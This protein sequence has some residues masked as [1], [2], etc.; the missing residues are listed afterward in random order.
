MLQKNVVSAFSTPTAE[1]WAGAQ[2]IVPLMIGAMPLGILFGTLAVEQGFSIVEALA[3]SAFV[4]AGSSQFIALG[5]LAT[6]TPLPLILLTTLIV[7]L[8]HLLYAL[9]LLPHIKRLSQ[10]WRFL[11]GFWLTDESFAV[12]IDRY[13]RSDCSPF[14]HWYYLGAAVLMY[15]N[16]QACT[17]IGVWLGRQLPNTANWGLDFAMSV[18][19]IGM[20][21][22]YL[23]MFSMQIAVLVA[24]VVALL[25]HALPHQLGL[26]VAAM[27]GAIAGF[28]TDDY[29][30]RSQS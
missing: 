3:M 30:K 21:I 20:V 10:Q 13:R 14:K 7:N 1:F 29:G 24:G 23:Q 22:P 5:L 19:F 8:R 9:S 27:A 6:G 17:V 16:W 15:S 12:A 25:L 11:V 4:F 26:I 18:T 28:C 2:A